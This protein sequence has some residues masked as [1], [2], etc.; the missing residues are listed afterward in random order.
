MG[1]KGPSAAEIAAVTAQA[2]AQVQNSSNAQI[3]KMFENSARERKDM[4]EKHHMLMLRLEGQQEK[5]RLEEA[6]YRR[7]ADEKNAQMMALLIEANKKAK[8]IMEPK[9]YDTFNKKNYDKYLD[10]I[11]KL[12]R[13]PKTAKFS[14]AFLGVT[15]SGKTTLVNTLVGHEVGKP[16]PL[17]NTKGINEVYSNDNVTLYDVFGINDNETYHNFTLLTQ[18]MTVHLVICLYTNSVE[19][20]QSLALLLSAASCQVH[21]VFSKIDSVEEEDRKLILDNDTK[22]LLKWCKGCTNSQV[23]SK[24]NIGITEMKIKCKLSSSIPSPL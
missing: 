17:R 15:C 11:R 19:S 21:F 1:N 14:I 3:Q 9:E 18:L 2:V 6:I 23:S 20:V 8:N 5:R 10:V 24:Q 16:S 13:P 4:Q 12:N 7:K 22:Q